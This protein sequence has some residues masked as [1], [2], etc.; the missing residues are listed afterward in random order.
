MRFRPLSTVLVRAAVLPAGHY[1]HARAADPEAGLRAAWADP[2]F[3]EAVWTASPSL[4]ADAAVFAADPDRLP[5]KKRRAV[6]TALT[7]YLIRATTRATPFGTFAGVTAGKWGETLDVRLASAAGHRRRARPDHDKIA[8]LARKIDT[9]PASRAELRVYANPAGHELGGRWVLAYRVPESD[10]S[11][12]EAV[13]VR[14]S[15]PVRR[16]LELARAPIVWPDLL[17]RLVAEHPGADPARPAALLETLFSQGFLLSTVLPPASSTDPAGE[18]RRA[19]PRQWWPEIDAL[20]ATASRLDRTPLGL[21]A[22]GI[23]G[24]GAHVDLALDAE[25]ILPAQ[26]GPEL[27][28]ALDVLARLGGGPAGPPGFAEYHEDFLARYGN[29]DVP[30][31][32]L[33]D[34]FIGLG[35]P[36]GYRNPPSTR[37]EPPPTAGR[38]DGD[39]YLRGLVDR[40]LREGRH[41]IVLDPAEV[42]E[43]VA[44]PP[45]APPDSLDVFVHWGTQADGEWLAVLPPSSIVAPAGRATGRFAY[46]DERLADLLAEAVVVERNAQPDVTFAGLTYGHPSGRANNVGRVPVVHEHQ[47]ALGATPGVPPERLLRLADI[48]VRATPD[49]LILVAE[50]IPGRLMVRESHLL[51]PASAPN[52]VRFLVDCSDPGAWVTPW[53]WGSLEEMPFLPRIRVGRVVLAPARWRVPPGMSLQAWR[54]RARPPRY[55]QL[56]EFD[57]RLLL[58]LDHP[59]HR[60]LAER[61]LRA[62]HTTVF[63][64]LPGLDG[65]VA[66]GPGGRH[67][68]EAVV[69]MRAIDPAPLPPVA[70][71]E[72]PATGMR[73]VLPGGA[74]TYAKLYGPRTAQDHVLALLDSLLPRGDWFFVR[75]ADP[76]PHLRIRVRAGELPDLLR[77]FTRTVE[78][79]HVSRFALDG[80]ERE[81]ERYGGDAGLEVCETVFCADTRLVLSSPTSP[82]DPDVRAAIGIETLLTGLGAGAAHRTETYRLLERGYTAEHHDV[83]ELAPARLA[84]RFQEIRTSLRDLST[85]DLGDAAEPLRAAG[86]KLHA[87]DRAGELTGGLA[88][89]LTSVV[90]LHAN[91][92]GLDRRAEHRVVA[93]LRRA[94]DDARRGVAW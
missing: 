85:V 77:A 54:D 50:D 64:A 33:L 40:A 79:G 32:E 39:A 27:D 51:N 92:A 31:P 6:V 73:R 5:A 78:S 36:A 14:Y 67:V 21:C 61:E 56:G 4:A 29:R 74:W 19:A 68:V 82:A 86:E 43:R 30:L 12:G 60:D 87:L 57:N 44:L 8:R 10:G 94:L 3:A 69:S 70:P 2:L 84:R 23:P 55:V 76:L 72:R 81:I 45:G 28:T 52:A 71:P 53:T 18:L 17:A 16:V 49:G 59:G 90:H 26:L 46:L 41:E 20:A 93:L 34:P 65:A 63:E 47:I 13:S 80:Y 62:G 25:A 22:G 75:F 83:P 35:P 66:T 15:G 88:W 9:D 91:R 42:A 48:R 37:P 11:L 89:V 7:R 58:D 1:R 24:P 38:P